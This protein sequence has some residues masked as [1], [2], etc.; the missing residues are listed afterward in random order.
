MPLL[1]LLLAARLPDPP[2][3]VAELLLADADGQVLVQLRQER[4]WR[5]RALPA[6]LE[7]LQDPLH[8]GLR[9][10]LARAPGA[11]T[12]LWT[13]YRPSAH[14]AEG[15]TLVRYQLLLEQR[16]EVVEGVWVEDH[17]EVPRRWWTATGQHQGA[18]LELSLRS[19]EDQGAATLRGV[20]ATP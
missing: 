20:V 17:E 11:R 14:E 10:E 12:C 4:C 13:G 9:L 18:R 6:P 2:A 19:W 16:E 5:D 3:A 8:T 15:D 1:L 7:T